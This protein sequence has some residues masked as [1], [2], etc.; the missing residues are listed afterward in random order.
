VI[1]RSI[2]TR[3]RKETEAAVRTGGGPR[4]RM[5][6]RCKAVVKLDPGMARSTWPGSRVTR[7]EV[8]AEAAEQSSGR[9]A[10]ALAEYR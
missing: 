2:T 5:P 4:V 3:T 8:R 10:L 7:A 1:A 6:I 9:T